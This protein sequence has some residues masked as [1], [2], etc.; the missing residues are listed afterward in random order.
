M[1][2][3]EPT[4]S[5]CHQFVPS[6]TRDGMGICCHPN[7]GPKP[8]KQD[9]IRDLYVPREF[10]CSD[11]EVRMPRVYELKGLDQL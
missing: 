1:S 3:K 4:C 11:F 9:V 5:R 8:R 7:A 2:Q 10:S 6:R